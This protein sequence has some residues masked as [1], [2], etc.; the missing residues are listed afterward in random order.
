MGE[1]LGLVYLGVLGVVTTEGIGAEYGQGGRARPK[2]F[3]RRGGNV[4]SRL[5]SE[6]LVTRELVAR[7][8]K[9]IEYQLMSPW[10]FP[11]I[12]KQSRGIRIGSCTGMC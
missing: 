9:G 8:M 11:Q 4:R 7:E 10:L 12:E 2:A 5:Y 6:D 3:V 1:I